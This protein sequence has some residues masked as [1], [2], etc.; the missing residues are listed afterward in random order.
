[1]ANELSKL[2]FGD[3]NGDRNLKDKALRDGLSADMDYT[4]FDG[5]SST[6]DTPQDGDVWIYD[7]TA[8]KWKPVA[9]H[10]VVAT[11]TPEAGE[12]YATMGNKI[13]DAVHNLD[14]SL[15]PQLKLLEGGGGVF[16]ASTNIYTLGRASRASGYCD[17]MCTEYTGAIV[18]Y[19]CRTTGSSDPVKFTK[20][21][22][23]TSTGT[24]AYTDNS[25]LSCN[26]TFYLWV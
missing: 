8:Q 5:P 9:S 13:A 15:L 21:E 4:G 6:S 18:Q 20:V 14:V 25:S 17:F 23:N 19:E 7:G 2:N 26:T 24:W 3:G 22:Y 11:I 10:R 16:N 12:T 1:M